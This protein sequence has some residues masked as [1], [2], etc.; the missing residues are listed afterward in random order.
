MSFGIGPHD[1]DCDC[2]RCQSRR[3][4]AESSK[5][6]EGPL[7]KMVLDLIRG[8]VQR[9]DVQAN[10]LTMQVLNCL[11]GDVQVLPGQTA[12]R[13]GPRWSV[14]ALPDRGITIPCD[15]TDCQWNNSVPHFH[16]PAKV[17]T[18]G[19]AQEAPKEK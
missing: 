12:P 9:P 17:E 4:A 16:E 13:K 1:Y 6:K 14:A 5:A 18:T 8:Y 15:G 2:W 19:Q 7:Q 10:T 11:A 3:K